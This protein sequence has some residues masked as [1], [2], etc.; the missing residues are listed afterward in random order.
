[1]G[2]HHT[3]HFRTTT[4]FRGVPA[5]LG[6]TFA[7]VMPDGPVS[8]TLPWKDRLIKAAARLELKT[9]QTRRTARTEHTHRT[10]LRHCRLRHAKSERVADGVRRDKTASNPGQAFRSGETPPDPRSPDD[11]ADCYDFENGRRSTL[12]VVDLCREIVN[13]SV[14]AFCC[15]ET[16]DLFDG[17]YVTSDR[18]RK[19][20]YLVLASDFIALC[21][22]IG[23]GD[24]TSGLT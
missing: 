11:I 18:D 2:D 4:Q 7:N 6:S 15:G 3:Q 13:S 8:D 20:V 5:S 1:M 10:G 17:V 9:K 22:D 19:Y 16:T 23:V 24:V 21:G 14:F 12:S